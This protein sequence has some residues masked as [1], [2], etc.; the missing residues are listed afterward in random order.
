MDE[1]CLG[2]ATSFME[3]LEPKAMIREWVRNA[4]R[5]S[6]CTGLV[7]SRLTFFCGATVDGFRWAQESSWRREGR[8]RV[9]HLAGRRSV[10]LGVARA[11]LVGD[12]PRRHEVQAHPKP[13]PPMERQRGP[14]PYPL[15][16]GPVS[17]YGACFRSPE[18]L[19]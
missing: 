1:T 18:Y 7:V 9:L 5:V 8:I 15:E 6:K 19:C 3:I 11:D 10:F 17:E 13:L 16:S 2:D 4:S 12:R 14:V